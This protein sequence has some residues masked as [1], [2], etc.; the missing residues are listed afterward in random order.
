[1][2]D[3]AD[4]KQLPQQLTQQLEDQ[5]L[6]RAMPVFQRPQQQQQQQQQSITIKT[7]PSFSTRVEVLKL[8]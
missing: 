3:E 4:F 8:Q 6:Q 2:H 5:Q 7:T 1:M